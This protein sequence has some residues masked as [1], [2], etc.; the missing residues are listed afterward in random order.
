MKTFYYLVTEPAIK[1]RLQEELRRDF[2]D[3]I[4]YEALVEHQVGNH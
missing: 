1:E 3:G 4:T 2:K